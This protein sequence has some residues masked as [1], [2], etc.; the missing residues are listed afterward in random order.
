M[1]NNKSLE[2]QLYVLGLIFFVLGS[3][4]IFLYFQF[5][6]PNVSIKPCTLFHY[7]GIYCPGCGGTRA[8]ITLLKG[9]L[10]QSLWYHPIVLYTVVIFGGFMLTQTCERL[11]LFGIRGWKFHGWHLYGALVL[12][13]LDCLRKNILLLGYGIT[14]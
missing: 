12:I 8:V 11:R 13:V 9:K 14:L 3:I 1:N 2:N 10:L 4:G 5:I 7:F 6:L